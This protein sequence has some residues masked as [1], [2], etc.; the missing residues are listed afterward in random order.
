MGNDVDSITQHRDLRTG[1]PLWA[2][3][4]SAPLGTQILSSSAR[5]DVVIA[6][7]GITGALLAEAATARGLSVILLDRRPPYHGSTAAS[8]ALL[9]FEIDTP[10]IRL[11]DV[12]GFE[13]AKRVWLRSFRA[14]GD[15]ALLVR[16][17]HLRCAFRRRR[18]LYL[19]GNTLGLAELAEEGVVRRSIGLPSAFLHAAALQGLAGIAREAALL[20]DGAADVN[21]V[22]LT[23]GLLRRSMARGA[24][25]Y[26]PAQLA[27]VQPRA[28]KC[29]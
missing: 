19:P 25:L 29:R 2:R 12:I 13:K 9:Q 5:T 11:A 1:T 24:K 4:G 14:L 22:L 8:T 27:E 6:G 20:S 10:L 18:S 3:L 15:L 16:K 28:A 23:R 26:S 17:L 7:A 21:P